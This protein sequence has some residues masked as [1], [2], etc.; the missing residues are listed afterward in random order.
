[1]QAENLEMIERINEEIKEF[2]NNIKEN[3]KNFQNKK[4]IKNSIESK[5]GELENYVMQYNLILKNQE[6]NSDKNLEIEN[7][8]RKK[9]HNFDKFNLYSINEDT[10]RINFSNDFFY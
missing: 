4:C 3:N 8:L 7:L 9:L 5:F 6:H 1:M 2:E 10:E